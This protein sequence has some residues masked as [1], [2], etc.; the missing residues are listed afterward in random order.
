MTPAPPRAPVQLLACAAARPLAAAVAGRLKAPLVRS[1]DVWF[2][3][4]EGKHVIED[5]VRGADLYVFQSCVGAGDD[6]SPYDRF[7]MLL[8]AV[9]AAA[10]SDAEGVTAVLPCFPGARQDKRKG[11]V[12]EGISAGLFARALQEAGASRVL[13]ID[14]HNEAIAGMFDPGR[15]RL[16]NVHLSHRLARF[17]RQRGLCG[18]TVAAPDVGGMERARHMAAELS[19]GLVALSKERDYSTVNRV[20]RSTLIGDVRDQDV[21]LI[22]DIIDTAGSVVAAVEALK[23]A[24]ARG[25]TVACSHPIMSGPAWDRL[26]DIADGAARGG[27]R[28]HV[29]GSG[30][31]E[32]SAPPPWYTRFPVDGLLSEVIG[33]ING[34]RSVTEVQESDADDEG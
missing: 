15:C 3:C 26:R 7:V 1:Q 25:V 20:L 16:E 28:F 24:G 2:S 32:H 10:L 29:V 19:A 31:V 30:S 4:G 33:H 18:T 12:R 21:L 13:T 27:W 17:L 22:D 6:R 8:H 9:E 34:R 11:R 14:I 23:D 5:N